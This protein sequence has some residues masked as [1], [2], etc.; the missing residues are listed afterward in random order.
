[1][2]NSTVS[3]GKS[4]SKIS[5]VGVGHPRNRRRS[6]II[7]SMAS[8]AI[9]PAMKPQVSVLSQWCRSFERGDELGILKERSEI[10]ECRQ[11]SEKELERDGAARG[12][13][14][15]VMFRFGKCQVEELGARTVSL[16]DEAIPHA[17][18]G[19]VIVA[20]PAAV[21]I[22]PDFSFWFS[23][24]ALKQ[25]ITIG[26]RARETRD[27]PEDIAPLPSEVKGNHAAKRRSHNCCVRGARQRPILRVDQWLERFDKKP[28]VILIAGQCVLGHPLVRTNS[29]DD[30]LLD[31]V[32][33][34]EHAEDL[35]GPP[36]VAE[37]CI[38][39]EKKILAVVHVE[40]RVFLE[41][42]LVVTGR[43]EHAE[44]MLAPGGAGERRHHLADAAAGVLDKVWMDVERGA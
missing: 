5:S 41:S 16:P 38:F 40:D 37:K 17:A 14:V 44:P 13:R 30:H 32:H 8:P 3:S 24:N 42:V 35:V 23:G 12:P 22:N 33:P 36:G 34:I 18:S 25:I 6:A 15:L 31:R 10:P 26:E 4:R 9:T 28:A 27:L 19:F 39:L 20:G 2:K 7:K 1:M 11:L 43:Q 29:D 21:E